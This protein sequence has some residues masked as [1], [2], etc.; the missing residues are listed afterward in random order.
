MATYTYR[1]GTRVNLEKSDTDFVVRALPAKL[2][3]FRDAPQKQV[4]SAS[5]RV[6]VE[7]EKAGA[8]AV[9]V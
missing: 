2:A 5:T 6:T 7:A 3:R 1:N 8:M 9:M 4:S